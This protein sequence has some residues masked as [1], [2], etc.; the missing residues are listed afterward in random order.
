MVS[1][2]HTCSV[3]QK[4][5]DYSTYVKN[6]FQNQTDKVSESVQITGENQSQCLPLKAQVTTAAYNILKCQA[7]LS[8]KNNKNKFRLPSATTLL[9][10]LRVNYSDRYALTNCADQNQGSSLIRVCTVCYS[11]SMLHTGPSCSKCR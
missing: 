8:L 4:E 6:E 10:T 3:L 2:K 11:A 5:T 9:G 1:L 7:L